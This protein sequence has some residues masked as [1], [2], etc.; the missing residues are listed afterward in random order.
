MKASIIIAFYN[1]IRYLEL[2]LAG[3]ERQTEKDFELIIADDGSGKEVVA[4]IKK[5]IQL[6]DMK[7]SHIWH[8]DKG[9]RKNIIM[10]QAVRQAASGDLI[11]I[12]GECIP[13]RNFIRENIRNRQSG[14]ILSGRRINL[15]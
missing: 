10:N 8:E 9:W 12:D 3:F 13:H 14:I 5:L 1:K 11:C 2:V 7:I 6:S 15:S 4:G